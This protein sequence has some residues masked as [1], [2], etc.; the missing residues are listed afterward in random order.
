MRLEE[1]RFCRASEDMAESE[2]DSRSSGKPLK[3]LNKRV[4]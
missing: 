2:F 1:A 3:G 4:T